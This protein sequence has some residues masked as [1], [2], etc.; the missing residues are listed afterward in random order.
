MWPAS[1]WRPGRRLSVAAVST[2]ARMF[3]P[4]KDRERPLEGLACH[5]ECPP[6]WENHQEYDL[7]TECGPSPILG[8]YNL[9]VLSQGHQPLNPSK[10]NPPQT[11]E[12]EA[13]LAAENLCLG[14]RR[15]TRKKKKGRR[16][17]NCVSELETN[18]AL[19]PPAFPFHVLFYHVPFL[20]SEKWG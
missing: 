2:E 12:L 11:A 14:L 3:P 18:I 1:E 13:P 6:H 16:G 20:L 9:G 10:I 5:P 4:S 7:D 8:L 15:I 19:N 17:N